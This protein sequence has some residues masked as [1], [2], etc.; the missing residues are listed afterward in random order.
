MTGA[1]HALRLGT[2]GSPLAVAQSR[3]VAELLQSARSELT[4]ELVTITTRGDR[5]QTTPLTAI[6]DGN[7]FSAEID[8]ALLGG[9][10]DFTVHSRKDLD[11]RRP[12]GIVTAAMPPRANPR[13]VALF[14][15]AVL[16]RLR[17]GDT[18]RIGTSSARRAAHVQRFL[19]RALPRIG[20]EPA[21]QCVPLRGPVHRRVARLH[22]ADPDALDGVV[23][24]L[25]GLERLW[26]D[27]AARA[28]IERSLAGLRW[29][30]LPL[31]E[32]P[33]A[34]GQGA[35]AVE[36][37]ADDA[38]TRRLLSAV[39]DDV[40]ARNVAA[41]YAAGAGLDTEA[42]AAMGATAIAVPHVG[43]LLF[44]SGPAVDDRALQ[45]RAPEPPTNARAWDG[46][47]WHDQCK[48]NAA[49]TLSRVPRAP[50]VFVAHWRAVTPHTVV[51]N[52]QRI[53]VSGWPSWQRLSAAG[54]W[55]EGC[56]ESL[57]FDALRPTLAAQVLQLP[58]LADWLVLT[59]AGAEPTW[60]DSGIATVVG[61][62][63]LDVPDASAVRRLRQ[64]A[65]QSTHFF[66]S[67]R[68]QYLALRDSL[69]PG[70]HHAC[71]TGKTF[72]ALTEL[73][74]QPAAFPSREAWQTWLG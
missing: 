54:L 45:W 50:A 35:L 15:P 1:A 21:L 32:C 12:A 5:N 17:R 48:Q 42:Q 66:W 16:D 36:C 44:A 33:T 34:P 58:P 63:V 64:A 25:A 51:G 22:D 8:A 67:S 26:T 65:G 18:L 68:D 10:V 53:W 31:S 11:G 39:H 69:P 3:Q 38:T 14:G 55:V 19:A 40:T 6:K 52:D 70:A 56:A 61:S 4:V 27:T 74:V 9:Q 7:F 46:S 62:Y 43:R 71:G 28:T 72:R 49:D 20:P 2:R 41:E 47:E 73:G 59:R 29:M 23:L 30:V 13:D 57:G 60:Q 37:R 24:A